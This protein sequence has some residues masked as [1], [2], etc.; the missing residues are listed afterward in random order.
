MIGSLGT[1]RT[2]G[3]TSE[4]MQQRKILMVTTR[5]DSIGGAQVHVRDLASCLVKEGWKVW[6][7]AGPGKKLESELSRNNT[8][9]VPIQA[10]RNS[11]NVFLAGQAVFEL[12]GQIRRL[13]PDIVC[14]HS[15]VAGFIARTAARLVGV[16]CVFTSHSWAFAEGNPPLRIL[17]A[18]IAER[19]YEPLA[20]KIICA[21]EY[22][23]GIGIKAGM[24]ASKL[25]TVN[26]GLS[27]IPSEM[28]A[29]PGQA[30]TPKVLM[31][32]R[33][34]RQKDHETLLRAAV[35]V[36]NAE[37]ILLG[38]G[39]LLEERKALA[40]ELGLTDRVQFLGERWGLESLFRDVHIVALA[41]KYEAISLVLL[42]AMRAG[43]PCVCSDVGGSSEAIVDGLT[44]YLVPRG[45]S[46]TFADRLNRL[47]N[48]PAL[49][50]KMGQAGRE[51][52]EKRFTIDR[53]GKETIQVYEEVIRHRNR[54]NLGRT[55][56]EVP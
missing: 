34:C 44:G 45:D 40:A 31:V 43:L 32:G 30:V 19:L 20:D 50:H 4:D 53:M 48:D 15:T 49:R 24:S 12:A 22:D 8:E 18:R 33:F 26:C 7:S 5:A 3:R 6:V 17:V 21:A 28:R 1:R 25:V 51:R 9:F 10:M 47:A 16:P 52:Y 13:K 23:R 37:F 36:P 2:S 27:D 55:V 14:A 41:T 29:N 54:A 11:V 35:R 38:T 46:E 56:A 39:P 42:D